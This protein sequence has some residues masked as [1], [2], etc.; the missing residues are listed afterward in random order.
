[1]DEVETLV[2]HRRRKPVWKGKRLM[3]GVCGHVWVMRKS[4]GQLRGQ[5]RCPK[6]RVRLVRPVGQTAT[7]TEIRTTVDAV[8][9]D[10]G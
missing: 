1:M 2:R 3:C 7:G 9:S 10:R 6:C 5:R 4:H 8:P